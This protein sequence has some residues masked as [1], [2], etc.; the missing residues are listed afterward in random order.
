[1]A[2]FRGTVKGTAETEAS[3]LGDKESFLTVE[4]NGYNTGILVVAMPVFN[5]LGNPS[6]QNCFRVFITKGSNNP[7]YKQ[8]ITVVSEMPDGGPP[9]VSY[10]SVVGRVRF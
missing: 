1:M 4:A 7:H 9:K 3:R 5:S 6:A 2:R 8:L 10:S